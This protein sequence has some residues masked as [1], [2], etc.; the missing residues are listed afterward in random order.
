MHGLERFIYQTDMYILINRQ[1]SRC[2]SG[3]RPT[4]N[5]HVLDPALALL[6]PPYFQSLPQRIRLPQHQPQREPAT[7][8]HSSPGISFAV[9]AF[10]A[11]AQAVDFFVQLRLLLR[12]QV[13]LQA[14]K[15]SRLGTGDGQAV[16]NGFDQRHP[17][18]AS[19]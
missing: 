15:S 11:R 16:L 6:A 8:E 17:L 7:F 12:V 4:N 18:F 5:Q 10:D 1:R 19:I 3:Y 13:E 2:C 9:S 14:D